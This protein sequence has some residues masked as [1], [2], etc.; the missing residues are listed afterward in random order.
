MTKLAQHDVKRSVTEWQRLR[1]AFPEID[2]HIREACVFARS[3][4]Q[5]RSKIDTTHA[6]SG[7]RGGNRDH[8]RA[9]GDVKNVLSSANIRPLDQSRRRRRRHRL[10]G[11][12]IFPALS[13]RLF[14][15]G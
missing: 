8:A 11:H 6:C 5:L 7:P 9:A 12:E 14:E 13:L 2:F 4:E 1:V 10:K 15:F 3:L